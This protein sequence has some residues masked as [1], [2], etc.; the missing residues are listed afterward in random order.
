MAT[1]AQVYAALLLAIEVDTVDEKQYLEQLA[2][3][4]RLSRQ[5]VSILENAV[6][7]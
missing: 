1:M 4:L 2:D 7:L 6:G 3:G 5:T